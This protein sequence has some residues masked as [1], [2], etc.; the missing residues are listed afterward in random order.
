M[1]LPWLYV[2]RLIAER[3]HLPPPL[4]DEYPEEEIRTELALLEIEARCQ[5]RPP[6]RRGGAG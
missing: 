2:R 5:P 4:V 3:W 1:P 6:T